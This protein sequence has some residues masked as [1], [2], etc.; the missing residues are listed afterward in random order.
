MS[1]E[2]QDMFP[3]FQFVAQMCLGEAQKSIKHL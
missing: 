1:P 2:A 3:R